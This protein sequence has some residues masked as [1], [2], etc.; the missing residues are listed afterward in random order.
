MLGR[1]DP[2]NKLVGVLLRS[3][4]SKY[5]AVSNIEQIFHQISIRPE[6]EDAL[7]FL[8]QDD[9]TKAI[10]DH[11]ICL[12]VF[13]KNNSPCTSNWRLKKT[14]RDNE[15]VSENII[16]QINRNRDMNDFLSSHS[17]IERL[18][19]TAKTI[20]KVLSNGGFGLA[21]WLSND[22]SF[23]GTL[24]Y[25]EVSPKIS[26]NQV[27]IEKVLGILWNFETDLLSIEPINKVFVRYLPFRLLGFVSSL[28][29][30]IGM[31][32]PFALTLPA[33]LLDKEKKLT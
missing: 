25:S 4:E 2:L 12:Q 33:P 28:F 6:D 22:K 16:D 15:V 9:K 21:K 13:R 7:R 29:E 27:Q 17:S 10:E 31:I 14:A 26:D 8:W 19:T 3:R 30:P 32:A 11:M 20:I 18:S 5:A 23:L 1:S 24:P